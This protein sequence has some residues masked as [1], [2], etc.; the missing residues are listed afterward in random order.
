MKKSLF[1]LISFILICINVKAQALRTDLAGFE[2]PAEPDPTGYYILLNESGEK[3]VQAFYYSGSVPYECEWSNHSLAENISSLAPGVYTVL[4]TDDNIRM[5]SETSVL[6][7]NAGLN[8]AEP[9]SDILLFP[10]PARD[11]FLIDAG[12]GKIQ[13]A[14]IIN[15]VGQVVYTGTA[16]G[17]KI[18]MN[19][20]ALDDGMYMVRIYIN[21]IVITKKIYVV[22]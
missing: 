15:V 5:S 20:S 13:K 18:H 2:S 9:Q 1:T 10:N 21:D 17:S 19:T 8:P 22:R 4:I 7:F 3:S 16:T 12:A 11:Y 6:S 14:E